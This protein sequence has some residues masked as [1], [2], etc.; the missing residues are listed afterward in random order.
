MKREA[1]AL[2]YSELSLHPCILYQVCATRGVQLLCT[3][4]MGLSNL[5][6][7]CESC[8]SKGSPGLATLRDVQMLRGLLLPTLQAN[9]R[10]AEDMD[11]HYYCNHD[12]PDREKNLKSLVSSLRTFEPGVPPSGVNFVTSTI[13]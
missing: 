4:A 8:H 7:G 11:N 13:K 12:Y 5:L 2:W 10:P 9:K 3:K 1:T 6:Y